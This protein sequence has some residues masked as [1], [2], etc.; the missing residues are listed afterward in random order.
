M[1]SVDIVD[2]DGITVVYKTYKNDLKWIKYS[3][4]TLQKF[5][6]GISEILIY[7][8]DGCCDD[9]YEIINSINLKCRIIPVRYDYH[10][11]LKQ[12]TVK[13]CCF[14]DVKTKYVAIYDSDNIFTSDFNIRDLIEESGKIKWLYWREGQE[15][16]IEIETWREAYE[17]M[18]KTKQNVHYMNNGFPFLFTKKSLSNACDKFH[19]IHGV[20]YD[21]FC[22]DGCI[23]YN[24]K[25]EEAISGPTG[26]FPDLSK[27]FEEFEWLGY[28]CHNFSDDYIFV[29]TDSCE[30]GKR[31][32]I[33][34]FWSH[35][36]IT[37][38]IMNQIEDLLK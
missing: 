20:N 35:G 38:D 21:T 7:C 37:S 15:R 24:I 10:G 34:Q 27:I 11:Y 29:P 26:R 14:K 6:K 30:H 3:L 12:M 8:H 16:T 33:I 22:N 13:A 18:T 28:Y 9:L 36:G 32:H 25:V 5:V 31:W 23:K 4:L 1:E 2:H 19:E 17:A